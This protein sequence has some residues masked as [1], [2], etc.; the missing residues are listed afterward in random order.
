MSGKCNFRELESK[1]N[2][3]HNYREKESK[4]SATCNC[5]ELGSKEEIRKPQVNLYVLPLLSVSRNGFYSYV[6]ISLC[7]CVCVCF[8]HLY[9]RGFCVIISCSMKLPIKHHTLH[10]SILQYRGKQTFE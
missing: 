4:K 6:R 3:T 8:V 2:G 5:R 10:I 7:V 9:M 1:R